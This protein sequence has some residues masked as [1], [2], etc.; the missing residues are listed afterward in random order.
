MAAELGVPN[1]QTY[2]DR[3]RSR[4]NLPSIPATLE[5]IKNE[6]RFELAFEGVRYYDLLRWHDEKLI[7]DNQKDIRVYDR[8][9]PKKKT[10][11]FRKE[12]GGFLPI[13]QSE[14]ELSKGVLVQNP[15]WEGSGHYLD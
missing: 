15:G 6:R 3:V 4:V 5:N 13:P 11:N 10:V 7:D 8:K 14:I 1:A 2:F 12:T 9:V